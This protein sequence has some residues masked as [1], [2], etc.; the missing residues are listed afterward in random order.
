MIDFRK[1]QDLSKRYEMDMV[2]FLRDMIRIP[3]PSSQEKRVVDRVAE[4][5]KKVG[6]DEVQIDPFG[7]VIGRIGYG[8]RIIAYDAHVDTVG[9]GNP[10]TW[11]FDP[12]EGKYENGI[13][14]GRGASDQEGGM[15][16]MVYAGKMMKELGLNKDCSCYFV[17]SIMEEDCDG[18]CW[19]YILREGILRPEVVII[20]EPTNLNIY[21]GH[22]GRMEIQ[23]TVDGR[24]CHAS[25]PERGDNAIYKMMPIVAEI[26][27]LN[28]R[29]RHDDF[30]GKGTIAVTE[31]SSVSPSFNAIADRCTISLDR[32]LTAGETKASSVE[33]LQRVLDT[34]GV[35]GKIEVLQY[36]TPTYRGVEYPVEKY[37][38]TWVFPEEHPIIQQ[39]AATYRSLFNREPLID[40]WTF[41][42][43]GIATAGIFSI[44]TFGF[45][46]ANEIYAHSNQDQCPSEHLVKAAAFYCAFPSHYR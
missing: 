6:F 12:Y 44:P 29:L 42:T 43:N 36:K 33:E 24:S 27:K 46:P 31:I 18:L 28:E 17:G 10:D 45:G 5:M 35:A 15:A 23:I 41:S 39:A 3:S 32:R 13:V 19:Q 40:K 37:F 4:E 7:N 20:T 30:L 1:I 8:K 21:R 9:I 38:P 34:Q 16:A 2:R 14:Y 25:A 11:D 22:R 26:E